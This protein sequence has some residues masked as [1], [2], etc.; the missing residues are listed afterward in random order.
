MPTLRVRTAAAA[1]KLEGSEGVDST[2]AAN[3]DAFL[4]ENIVVNFDPNIVQTNEVTPS[5]DPFDPIVGGTPVTIT[6]D[7]YLKGSGTP[8]TAPEFGPLLKACGWAETL[9]ATA[10]PASPEA[11]GSGSSTTQATL[12]ST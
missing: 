11:L 6:M 2:P 5:L 8:G 7:V 3:T 9:T 10:I 1:F 4:A 12:G